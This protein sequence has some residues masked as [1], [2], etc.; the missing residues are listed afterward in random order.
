MPRHFFL[1]S[2]KLLPCKK[3]IWIELVNSLDFQ[4]QGP[5][6]KNRL[7]AARVQQLQAKIHSWWIFVFS[8]SNIPVLSSSGHSQSNVA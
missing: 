7:E 6:S 3:K 8:L 4:T 2:S 1:L 5:G